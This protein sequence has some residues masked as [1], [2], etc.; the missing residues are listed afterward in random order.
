MVDDPSQERK[1]MSLATAV[2]TGEMAG[3]HEVLEVNLASAPNSPE[4]EN[5]APESETGGA[6][7]TTSKNPLLDPKNLPPPLNYLQDTVSSN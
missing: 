7:K 5:V 3:G 4:K 1:R 2:R 6:D